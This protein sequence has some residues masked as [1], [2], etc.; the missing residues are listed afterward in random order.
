MNRNCASVA[1]RGDRGTITLFTKYT[2]NAPHL[3]WWQGRRDTTFTLTQYMYCILTNCTRTA[4]PHIEAVINH[5]YNRLFPP[6][7]RKVRHCAVSITF[8]YAAISITV[9]RLKVWW[10]ANSL[11]PHLFFLNP[12]AELQFSSN[13]IK[14]VFCLVLA[15]HKIRVHLTPCCVFCCLSACWYPLGTLSTFIF[16]V[17]QLNEL[18]KIQTTVLLFHCSL[19]KSTFSFKAFF[20]PKSHYF[21]TLKCTKALWGAAS[22]L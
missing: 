2:S 10:R 18:I 20:C 8:F 14:F 16:K 5:S 22:I 1:G 6:W 12:S 19:I 13:W 11:T 9:S 21:L 17:W 4:G 3:S 15:L 7:S